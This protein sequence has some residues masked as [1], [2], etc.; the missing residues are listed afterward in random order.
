MLG[1]RNRIHFVVVELLCRLEEN[2]RREEHLADLRR[3]LALALHLVGAIE[4][5][6]RE[7]RDDGAA[8]ERDEVGLVL[9]LER[10]EIAEDV[11]EVRLLDGILG[12]AGAQDLLR[13][14]GS[15][16]VGG[17]DLLRGFEFVSSLEKRKDGFFQAFGD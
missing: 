2:R 11:E 1:S 9:L 16:E 3:A 15:H 17:E 5:R 8:V 6:Q 14:V 13:G 4:E 10:L 7:L 12:V